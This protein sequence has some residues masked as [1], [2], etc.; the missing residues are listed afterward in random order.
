MKI[1]RI[2]RKD[3]DWLSKAIVFG[4]VLVVGL[5]VSKIFIANQLATTGAVATAEAIQ[6]SQL[7]AEKQDL[8]N[9]V[10]SLGSLVAI[11]ARADQLG[12]KKSAKIQLLPASGNVAYNQ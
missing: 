1:D 12:L 5:L 10:S 8:Q 4:A 7:K 2:I 9:E 11:S 6:L 3:A